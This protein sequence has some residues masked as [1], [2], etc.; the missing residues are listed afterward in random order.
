[1]CAMHETYNLGIT[2]PNNRNL[3]F[4]GLKKKLEYKAGLSVIAYEG[5]PVEFCQN[6]LMD[7]LWSKQ[8]EILESVR[9]NRRTAVVSC[10]SAGKS[11]VISRAVLEW[12]YNSRLGESFVV[13][14]APTWKQVRNIIWREVNK[15]HA[16]AGLPGRLNQTEI[17]MQS[18]GS[19]SSASDSSEQL[20]AFGQ[21]PEDTN[22]SAFQGYHELRTLVIFDEA[23]GMAEPLWDAAASL[24]SNKFSRM[25][26]VG[27]G[28]FYWSR[29][30][31]V[32][33]PGSGWNVIKIPAS[34]TPNFTGEKV[35]KGVADRLITPLWVD[36]LKK[37]WGEDSPIYKSK[38][39]AE[40]PTSNESSLIKWHYLKQAI[41]RKIEPD[42]S[43]SAFGVDVGGGGDQ[44][45][46]VWRRG[47]VARVVHR[48]RDPNLMSSCGKILSLASKLKVSKIYVDVDGIGKGLV[49]R[50]QEIDPEG[51]EVV[52]VSASS[53]A[54]D[55]SHLNMGMA[56]AW[57]IRKHFENGTIDIDGADNELV[58][59]LSA[60]QIEYL[61][62]GKI[63]LADKKKAAGRSPDEFDALRLAYHGDVVAVADSKPKARAVWGCL[64]RP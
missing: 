25:L 63:K 52:G 30:R 33:E 26:V 37:D 15:A 41:E 19:T 36:E 18:T 58:L 6:V 55:K 8:K 14:S 34:C 53:A 1:M 44:T 50:A 57:N 31:E 4:E 12:A 62:S 28:D 3:F 21:K 61:S 22:I 38:V 35:P 7:H 16:A 54:P 56:N 32:C 49:E 59:Q 43:D 47:G 27:N 23:C 5:R 10:H 9:D 17:W 40:F 48:D 64:R 11:F 60:M 29:F 46:I 24:M 39:E 42:Y 51:I 45:V 2:D 13:T 20:V